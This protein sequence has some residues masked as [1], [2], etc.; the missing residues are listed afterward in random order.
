LAAAFLLFAIID[1][2]EYPRWLISLSAPALVLSVALSGS[3]TSLS[4]MSL[5]MFGVAAICVLQPKFVGGS[6]NILMTLAIGYLL[7]GSW[8][9]FS[10]GVDVMNYRLGDA[11]NIKT[12]LV[13][14]YFGGLL[15][16]FEAAGQAPFFGSGLGKGT[17]AG[18][19][20]LGG[21]RDFLLA[22]DE[23]SRIVLESG[24]VLG[25]AYIFLRVGIIAYAG[26]VAFSALL[27]NNVL[28]VFLFLVFAPLM[29]NGQFGQPTTLGFAVF[30]AGLCLASARQERESETL[31]AGPAATEVVIGRRGRSAYAEQL[32]SGIA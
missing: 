17:M 21:H 22:E 16:P 23:L 9:V 12:G 10:E 15:S 14:R 11:Q 3:R 20:L 2:K 27:R 26:K 32:H 1:K 28:P 6:V 25:F 24:P 13:D 29:L 19:A 5:L 30:G 8:S 4:A 7:V 18:A 31:A